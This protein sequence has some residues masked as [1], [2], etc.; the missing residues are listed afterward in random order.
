MQLSLSRFYIYCYSCM[1]NEIFHKCNYFFQ[2][3]C[4]LPEKHYS[5]KNVNAIDDEQTIMMKWVNISSTLFLH[6]GISGYKNFKTYTFFVKPVAC[7]EVNNQSF[8]F[9]CVKII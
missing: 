8:D 3:Y 5:W 2:K 7:L 4:E 9:H 1:F 6:H